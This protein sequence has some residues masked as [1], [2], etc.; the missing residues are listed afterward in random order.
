[1]FYSSDNEFLRRFNCWI[2]KFFK[3]WPSRKYRINVYSADAASAHYMIGSNRYGILMKLKYSLMILSK[4]LK[5]CILSPQNISAISQ[6]VKHILISLKYLQNL[7]SYWTTAQIWK[8]LYPHQ[9]TG[10][11]K[12]QDKL[13]QY[14]TAILADGVGLG[15]TRIKGVIKLSMK[16]NPELRVV[17]IADK[18]STI[19]GAKI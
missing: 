19:N 10:I 9:R 4:Q 2:F 14:G 3:E 6:Q 15:K 18:N 8:T 17:I 16:D 5:T 1:M 12:I 13:M 7:I 11:I